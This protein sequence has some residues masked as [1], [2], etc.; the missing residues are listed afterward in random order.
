ML[1]WRTRPPVQGLV[2]V[3][4]GQDIPRLPWLGLEAEQDLQGYGKN[5]GKKSVGRKWAK[6]ACFTQVG[7]GI[8]IILVTR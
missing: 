4:A 2:T 5:P 8:Q 7:A 1:G 3:A 6:S